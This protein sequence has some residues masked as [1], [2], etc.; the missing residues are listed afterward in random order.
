MAKWGHKEGQGLGAD[1]SGIVEPLSVQ[2]AKAPKKGNQKSSAG[3][4]GAEGSRVA[5]IVNKQEGE[6]MKEERAKY[7][8]P[9]TVVVL[10]NMVGL[11]DADDE[12]LSDEIGKRFVW[13]TIFPYS[14]L[15]LYI[16]YRE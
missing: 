12:E 9:S 15:N 5:K 11:E 10:S 13:S 2:V 16:F 7:G 4:F 1:A 6:R 3:G 14:R 8:D